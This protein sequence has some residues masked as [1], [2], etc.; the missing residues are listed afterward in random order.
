MSYYL[1]ELAV[2]LASLA[3]AYATLR[4]VVALLWRAASRFTLPA[5][6]LYA[7]LLTPAV[8]SLLFTL[9]VTLPA[10]LRFEPGY[11]GE[12]V[13]ALMI[14]L[15]IIAIVF[16]FVGVG[17]G[18]RAVWLTHRATRSWA[19]SH[20]AA[21]AM[22]IAG[23]CRPKLLVSG[24]AARMLSER[25]L[26]LAIEHELSHA[27]HYDN[28]KKL[29]LEICCVPRFRSLEDRWTAATELAAD[30]SSVRTRHDAVELASALV[31][32]SRYV[33]ESAPLVTNFASDD[34]SLISL[35]VERLLNW[36]EEDE[37]SRWSLNRVIGFSLVTVFS[38]ATVTNYGAILALVHRF[39]EFL[40]R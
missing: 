8:G 2:I 40:V 35:R 11:A 32:V 38:I 36:E 23:L 31:K 7:L 10:Y 30:H 34:H 5:N 20:S 16:I 9:L 6:A 26:Q 17:R 27:A 18:A 25:E 21:P 13:S 33:A 3:L 22:A 29:L 24:G 15:D 1:R 28:L 12:P 37:G 19:A 4:A 39:T 14:A